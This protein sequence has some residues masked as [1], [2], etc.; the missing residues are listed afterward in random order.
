MVD[1]CIGMRLSVGTATGALRLVR[2][3]RFRSV[4][5]RLLSSPAARVHRSKTPVRGAGEGGF[6]V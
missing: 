4:P 6:R 1:V 3:P 2:P 5:F